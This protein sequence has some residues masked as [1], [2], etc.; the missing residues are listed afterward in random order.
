MSITRS[1]SRR[2]FL[3]TSAAIA[4]A[5]LVKPRTGFT[6]TIEAPRIPAPLNQF[7]SGDVE[8]HERP[9]RDQY[10]AVVDVMV[11]TG[12]GYSSGSE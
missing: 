1:Q 6:N 8:L 3:E 5:A 10:N 7:G 2:A 9:I 4:A 12:N 11:E